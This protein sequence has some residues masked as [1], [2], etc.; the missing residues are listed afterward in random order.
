MASKLGVSLEGWPNTPKSP[1]P[2][3]ITK[4]VEMGNPSQEAEATF[5][6]ALKSLLAEATI[7]KRSLD[8]IT[9][10]HKKRQLT[11]SMSMMMMLGDDKLPDFFPR[12][13]VMVHRRN[14]VFTLITLSDQYR[15]YVE[16]SELFISARELRNICAYQGTKCLP[17]LILFF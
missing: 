12:Q 1:Q 3:W 17:K 10:T 13:H 4:A 11:S 7:S 2:I 9:A 8:K 15:L 6:D 14:K 5:G 16:G